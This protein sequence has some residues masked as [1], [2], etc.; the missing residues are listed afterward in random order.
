MHIVQFSEDII[1]E[2]VKIYEDGKREAF[3]TG[4]GGLVDFEGGLCVPAECSSI[5]SLCLCKLAMFNS[6]CTDM[7]HMY[8]ERGISTFV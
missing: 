8:G 6:R 7:G 3:T 2:G 5:V 1:Q 4:Q